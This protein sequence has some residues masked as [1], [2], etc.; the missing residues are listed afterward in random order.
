M[1]KEYSGKSVNFSEYVF[2]IEAYMTILDPAGRGGEL[3]KKACESDRAI[4]DDVLAAWDMEFW[5]VKP[6]SAALASCLITTTTGEVATL[7]RRIL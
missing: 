1:P 3:A 6:L 5:H 4:D 7:V 2:K